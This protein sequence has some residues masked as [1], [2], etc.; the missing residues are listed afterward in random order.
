MFVV[1]N[2]TAPL[3]FK[4]FIQL[5]YCGPRYQTTS[6][7]LSESYSYSS[8]DDG[9]FRPLS[10]SFSQLF[11]PMKFT[12]IIIVVDS[13]WKLLCIFNLKILY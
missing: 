3:L 4:W 11:T 12:W 9:K 8:C 5:F 7:A 10:I 2:Y 13:Y 1:H 6:H